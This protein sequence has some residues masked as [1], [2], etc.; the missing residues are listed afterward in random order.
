M[1]ARTLFLI[2]II[3]PPPSR[4][5]AQKFLK[6]FVVILDITTKCCY[7]AI[8]IKKVT[9]KNKDIMEEKI[10]AKI[11]VVCAA[12]KEGRLLV[13]EAIARGHEVTGFVRSADQAVNPAAKRWLKTFLTSPPQ[14]LKG[15]TL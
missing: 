6:K 12:G 3:L 13:E 11:A 4:S 5:A 7:T 9:T 15:S 2:T 1:G 14:T 8:V 10:M